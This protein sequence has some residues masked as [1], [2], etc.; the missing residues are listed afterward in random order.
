M[1]VIHDE[2]PRRKTV[3]YTTSGLFPLNIAAGRRRVVLLYC[4]INRLTVRLDSSQ[5]RK[6]ATV[7]LVPLV[8]FLL[9]FYFLFTKHV[10]LCLVVGL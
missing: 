9:F 3:S 4:G 5:M 8:S 7:S 10:L 2:C 6:S 1:N